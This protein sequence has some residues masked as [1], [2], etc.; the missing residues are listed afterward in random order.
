MRSFGH[1]VSVCLAAI[2]VFGVLIRSRGAETLVTSLWPVS[3]YVTREMM[4]SYYSG[5]KRGLGREDA[6]RQAQLAMLKHKDRSHSF[7]WDGFIQSGEW[8]NLD[9]KR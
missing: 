7:Y 1:Q 4:S 2:V 3:D 8:A 9:G 6:L 5:L